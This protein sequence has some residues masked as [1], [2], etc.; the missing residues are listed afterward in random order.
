MMTLFYL[1]M[2]PS[3][4]KRRCYCVEVPTP[5]L[6]LMLLVTGQLTDIVL[7]KVSS[8]GGGV[9]GSSAI[10]HLFRGV[11]YISQEKGSR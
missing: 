5:S 10:G 6:Q 8:A 1:L 11:I 9:C 7:Q 4:T 3:N 2:I